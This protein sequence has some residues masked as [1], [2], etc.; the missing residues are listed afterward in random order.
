[1]DNEVESAVDVGQAFHNIPMMTP[2][3]PGSS[4]WKEK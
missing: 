4:L 2:I 1:V 3:C